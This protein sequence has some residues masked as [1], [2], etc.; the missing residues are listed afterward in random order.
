MATLVASKDQWP[1]FYL[2]PVGIGIVNLVFVVVAFKDS[3]RL[4]RSSSTD[5]EDKGRNEI[6]FDEIK[7]VL[8]LKSVWILSMFYFFYLGVAITVGGKS[9]F[10]FCKYTT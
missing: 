6:A 10:C 5:G 4:K 7:A 9:N 3:I 1:L 8:S 2:F